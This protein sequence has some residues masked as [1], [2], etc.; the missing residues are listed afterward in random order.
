MNRRGQGGRINRGQPLRF[1]FDGRSY[2]GYDGD[3]LASALLAN[4]VRLM[5]RSF[6][7]HRPR[8]VITAGSEEPNALVELRRGARREPNT[9]ATQVEL[10]DGLE[11]RSQ[12][13]FPSLAFDA[14]GVNDRLS[15]VLG[16]GF[17][18][19]TF[20]W[21]AA[22]WETVYEPLIRR[23]A[24]LGRLAEAPDPDCYDKG[25]LFCDLLVIGA[26]PAGLAAAL[27]AG[28]AGARVILAD[29]DFE[30]GGRLLA[31][32]LSLG[33]ARAEEWRAATLE[34]LRGLTNVRL[35]TRTTVVG[36]Y[37][38]GVYGALERVTDHLAAPHPDL[39]R[40]I[41]WKIR[42]KRALVCTGATER[43]IAFGNNDRPGVM[44]AGA[45]RAY[46]NRWAVA[47][48]RTVAVF[49][50]NDDGHRTAMDLMGQGADVGAV[51]DVREDAPRLGDYPLF[52][53]AQVVDTAGRLGLK[54]I[55][56]R[57]ADGSTEVVPCGAL[58]VAGG[59]NPALALTCHQGGRPV[60]RPE[61]AT[62]V[63]GETLPE[64]QL[65]AGAA[66]GVFSTHG[67][68]STGVAAT[69]AALDGL[70]IR[71]TPPD[72]PRAEDA[73]VN[74][75]PFWHTGEGRGR[76]W[77]DLQN[78]V[79]V[80]DVALA[81]QEGFRSVEHLKRYTTLG[82]AT[83]QGKLANLGALAVM[84]E[85]TGKSIPETGTTTFRPPYTPV[86]IAAL[87]GRS[88]GREFR[89]TR[90]T[91][92]HDWAEAQ[93]AV[94][95]EAGPWLR[96]QYFPREGETHWRQSVDRE[97][98]AVRSSVGICDV[99]TLGKVDVQG[100]GAAEYLDLLY[101]NG[102]E[103]L[104][105]GKCRYGLM[106]REDGIVLDD[107][108]VARLAEA[109]FVVTTTTAN[110]AC[111]YRHMEFVRQC[112][113]PDLDVQLMP[114]TDA[115]AQ[116]AVA[117]PNARKLLQRIVDPV[118]DI[119]NDAFPFMACAAIRVCGGTPARLFRISFSGELAYE[120][121]VPACYGNSLMQVLMDV[122]TDYE[123][124]PYGTEALGVLRIE[125]GHATA[126]ELNG[127][128]SA[129][130]LGMARMVSANKDCIGGVLSR[131]PAL[132]EKGGFRLIGLEAIGTAELAAGSHL[133]EDGAEKTPAHDEG[134]TTSACYSPHLGKSI[135]LGFFER[136]D[137]R[138]GEVVE[139]ANPIEGA[140]V[141]A[142]VVSPHFIDP[143]GERL[144]G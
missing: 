50:N 136:G 135:A 66:A 144:R 71:T 51:V 68:V 91:P 86:P 138:W 140:S 24:G 139:V 77:L 131:R 29:E 40:Q 102:M 104:P 79:T 43:P 27:T 48:D 78:D 110:A 84:A 11:A 106:L 8:G 117:G 103:R 45:L 56:L 72:L 12:N 143:K 23:A 65:V 109:H 19:K 96:A 36:A 124:T 3:T 134:W 59:W 26:G 141:R 85:L 21:P 17:Y 98:L 22:F 125:K 123:V 101:A 33:D 130:H 38:N 32:R 69:V 57:R 25:T 7:Y 75:R 107:G 137:V 95:V 53:G 99:S 74:I 10:F 5:G 18:Y 115:W 55:T 52:A 132:S 42:S 129:T 9:R 111:V 93:G 121:A 128:T 67:A 92:G 82:M 35:K 41:F 114:V 15:S 119:S 100:R 116:V 63:P 120:I 80:K 54:S 20:M 62:F 88:R 94:F 46:A 58:G 112:L 76:S 127:Q 70:G 90:L 87:A 81:H 118:F 30:M 4:G 37:D 142:R 73:P 47:A 89:P 126:S 133:F 97:A 49:T 122:G 16:A 105:V 39:P 61:I 31:E 108:T 13:R 1:T 64:R 34:E 6:K 60:W 44:L 83:D 14:L 113:R 2:Q 28:R